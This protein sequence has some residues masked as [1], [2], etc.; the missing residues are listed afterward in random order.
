MPFVN[1]IAKYVHTSTKENDGAMHAHANAHMRALTRTHT[2]THT[3]SHTY[4]RART[5]ARIHPHR[6]TRTHTRTHAR[7]HT[8][9]GAPNKN[10]GDAF[11]LVWRSKNPDA[12]LADQIAVPGGRT[13]GH[14]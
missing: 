7:T 12:V 3:R 14:S 10:I 13:C 9:T 4:T 2:H 11:L 8:H 5:H 6:L 1:G